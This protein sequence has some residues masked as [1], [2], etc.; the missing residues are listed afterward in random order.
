MHYTADNC[1]AQVLRAL[2]GFQE[3]WD[4]HLAAGHGQPA[5]LLLDLVDLGAYANALLERPA[6]HGPELRT[7][8]DLVEA[9][10]VGG[11]TLVQSAMQGGLLES[12]LDP[13]TVDSRGLSTFAA[14]LGPR[15]R[16]YVQHCLQ[17]TGGRLPGL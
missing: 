6:Q 17:V 16:A 2:P 7:L 14:L 1:M 5:G 4:D 3:Q 11:D 8:F 15:S 9:M 10:I 12:V 13:M